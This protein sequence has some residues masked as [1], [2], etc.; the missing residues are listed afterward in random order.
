MQALAPSVS[1]GLSDYDGKYGWG[2]GQPGTRYMDWGMGRQGIGRTRV[3]PFPAGSPQLGRTRVEE[4]QPN[5][6][7]LGRLGQ[8]VSVGTWLS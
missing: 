2:M 1:V 7:M 6:F 5:E 3:E 8:D 4:R